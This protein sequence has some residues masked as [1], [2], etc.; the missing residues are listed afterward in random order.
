MYR[1]YSCI[2]F[3]WSV[4]RKLHRFFILCEFIRKNHSWHVDVWW[5]KWFRLVIW[6]SIQIY[7]YVLCFYKVDS[8]KIN[9]H[10]L[11]QGKY[12]LLWIEG[13]TL[14]V[15]VDLF[16]LKYVS[17]HFV[18]Y[19]KKFLI[20]ASEIFQNCHHIFIL[21]KSIMRSWTKLNIFILTIFL[22]KAISMK[23]STLKTF[24]WN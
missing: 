14:R 2:Q 21:F 1:K 3:G 18:F 13:L 9:N 10:C 6:N 8:E 4:F 20:N 12:N 17:R 11:I 5:N 7:S 23:I 24:I 16:I 15:F 19:S 22:I